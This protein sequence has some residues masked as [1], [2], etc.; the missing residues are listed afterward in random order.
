VAKP[1]IFSRE[2]KRK[3]RERRRKV[4]MLIAVMIVASGIIMSSGYVKSW[5]EK[6]INSVKN[7]RNDAKSL[8]TG[9]NNEQKIDDKKTDENNKDVAVDE[10]KKTENADVKPQENTP[11]PE[12]YH[13]IK[14]TD[15]K[16]IK[17]VYEEDSEGKK[18]KYIKDENSIYNSIS[19]NSKNMVIWDSATQNMMLINSEGAV[20]DITKPFYKTKNTGSTIKKENQLAK[21]PN[22]IWCSTPKFISDETIAYVTNLPLIT[23]ANQF[24]WIYNINKDDHSQ[25][26]SKTSNTITFKEFIEGKLAI[27]IDGAPKYILADGKVTD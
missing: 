9:K 12:K 2:Y 14:L 7:T 8:L 10:S 1:S 21:R 26:Y 17:V 13:E 22:Y 19:P 23:K 5:I 11:V 16:I 27:D 20:K 18:L 3:M 6:G 15:D 4:G 25:I 24:I